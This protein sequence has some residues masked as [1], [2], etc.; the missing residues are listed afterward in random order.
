MGNDDRGGEEVREED[1]PRNGKEGRMGERPDPPD[2]YQRDWAFFGRSGG[3]DSFRVQIL[4]DQRNGSKC[5]RHPRRS[6]LPDHRAFDL[7]RE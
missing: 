6:H 7:N 3:P 4:S 2:L 1:H 5:L